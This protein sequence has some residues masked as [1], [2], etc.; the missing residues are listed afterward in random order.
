MQGGPLAFDRHQDTDWRSVVKRNIN[1]SKTYPIPVQ[2][3]QTT[4]TETVLDDLSEL[5]Q[6]Q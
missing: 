4:D 6:Q 2:G 5:R 1:S 3:K